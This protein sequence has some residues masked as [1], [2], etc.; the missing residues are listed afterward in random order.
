MSCH[1]NRPDCLCE[2]LLC[3]HVFIYV[4]C[5]YADV[6]LDECAFC[7]H[8][9]ES[10]CRFGVQCRFLH[11]GAAAV[12]NGPAADEAGAGADGCKAAGLTNNAGI[13]GVQTAMAGQCDSCQ[14]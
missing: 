4:V 9:T 5:Y 1:H 10:G 8:S 2:N 11:A 14:R 12:A 6:K 7:V 3:L 13:D